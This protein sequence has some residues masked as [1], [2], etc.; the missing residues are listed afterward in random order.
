MRGMT[1]CGSPA[2]FWVKRWML[3]VSVAKSTSRSSE[4]ANCVAISAGR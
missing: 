4:R 2:K 1:M 3:R